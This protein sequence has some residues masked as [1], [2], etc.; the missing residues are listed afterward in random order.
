M[1]K[2]LLAVFAT[3]LFVGQTFAQMTAMD[4]SK[5][6][7]VSSAMISDDGSYVVYTLSVP[8]DPLKE[9]KRAESKL[10]LYDMA[11]QTSRPLVTQGSVYGVA[12]R[13]GHNSVTF[14]NKRDGDKTTSVYELSMLGGE[15][16]NVFSYER[17]IGS[18]EWNH[19]GTK[20]LF[21]ASDKHESNSA[22]PYEPELYEKNLSYNRAFIATLGGD[23]DVTQCHFDGHLVSMK[24]SP[25]GQKVAGFV[26]K[27]P[28]VDDFYMTRT[29][30]VVDANNGNLINRVDHDGKKGDFAWSPDGKHI[31][32]IAGANINDPIAG[33]LFVVDADKKE[34]EN[35]HPDFKG[36]F[37]SV[38]WTD[39]K[40]MRF[41]AS[42]GCQS[43]VGTIGCN[44]KKM[45]K[46]IDAVGP[47]INSMSWSKAGAGAFVASSASHPRE[48]YVMA[49]EGQMKEQPITIHG[50]TTAG[51]RSRKS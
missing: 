24:W 36:Q 48:L 11:T 22:L 47:V 32:F 28:L 27:T 10:Y 23:G 5:I 40:T 13:P 7:S 49:S 3:F 44:G 29:M 1:K 39:D 37:H 33:R 18:Y 31:A 41:L 46:L 26:A 15:A 8:A 51:W 9:N 2:F 17:S 19:D 43:S 4:V 14:L 30:Q 34:A 50:S 25:D 12:L 35:I 6:Q 45:T 20:L 16:Q 21:S 38:E 42:E